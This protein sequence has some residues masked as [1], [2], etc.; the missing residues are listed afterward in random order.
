MYL[1]QCWAQVAAFGPD[2]FKLTLIELGALEFTLDVLHTLKVIVDSLDRLGIFEQ[3]KLR[4]DEPKQQTTYEVEEDS[5]QAAAA[6][7]TQSQS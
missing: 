3:W 4:R 2:W 6:T 5:S 7:Q 1:V